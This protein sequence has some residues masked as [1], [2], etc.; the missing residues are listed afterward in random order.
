MHDRLPLVFEPQ[1]EGGYSVTSPALPELLSEGD[2]A[3]IVYDQGSPAG[4]P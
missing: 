4:F 1:P 3:V 2:S